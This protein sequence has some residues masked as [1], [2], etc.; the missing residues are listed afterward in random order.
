VD[1]VGPQLVDDLVAFVGIQ[2]VKDLGRHH[3][4]G[5]LGKKL[6]KFSETA[7]AFFG[8]EARPERGLRFPADQEFCR[9]L[10]LARR[11]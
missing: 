10:A 9:G 3:L 7:Q 5:R 2:G 8:V 11:V 1:D 4:G 6:C